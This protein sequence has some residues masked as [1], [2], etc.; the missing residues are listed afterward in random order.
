MALSKWLLGIV[1][2]KAGTSMVYYYYYYYY[3]Y[4]CYY[5]ENLYKYLEVTGN[6]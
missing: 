5:D 6:H 4:Y 3:Y 1:G 2:T